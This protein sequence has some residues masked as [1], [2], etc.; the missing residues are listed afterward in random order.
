M[1]R[2]RGDIVRI[3]LREY[4]S[5]AI[6]ESAKTRMRSL[7]GSLESGVADLAERHREYVLKSH[8]RHGR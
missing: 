5:E 1:Q 8:R 6:R 2:K 3:A 7:I 4:C